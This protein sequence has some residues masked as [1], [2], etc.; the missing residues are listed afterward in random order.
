MVKLQPCFT[1]KESFDSD[2]KL[3]EKV[4]YTGEEW[5]SLLAEVFPNLADCQKQFEDQA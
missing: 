2:A 1:G 3:Y 5:H 4:L